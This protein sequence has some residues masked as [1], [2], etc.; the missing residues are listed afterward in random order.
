VV[1][2]ISVLARGEFCK[3]LDL[4]CLS[5]TKGD[6]ISTLDNFEWFIALK[7]SKLIAVSKLEEEPGSNQPFALLMKK[8]C[9][10]ALKSCISD[11]DDDKPGGLRAYD[12]FSK[13]HSQRLSSFYQS[14]MK[15]LSSEETKT[16]LGTTVHNYINSY[17]QELSFPVIKNQA[18]VPSKDDDEAAEVYTFATVGQ[19]YRL[20]RLVLNI[21]EFWYPI[22]DKPLA[23][24]KF[25]F[26]DIIAYRFLPIAYALDTSESKEVLASL[27]K[28]MKQAGLTE[29]EDL[30]LSSS[31][32]RAAATKFE[33]E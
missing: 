32:F 25:C 24:A 23:L 3:K 30:M 16:T 10:T 2:F 1:D 22:L 18:A 26:T 4:L 33:I 31:P 17:L 11:D 19:L 5:E 29:K 8:I 6:S 20:K 12:P 15:N 21:V 27:W 13:R 9:F 14:V 7:D 28:A